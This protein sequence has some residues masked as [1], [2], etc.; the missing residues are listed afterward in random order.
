MRILLIHQNYPGQYREIVPRLAADGSHDIHFL[1]Q[2]KTF[3]DPHGHS[4]HRYEPTELPADSHPFTA[5]YQ[6][7]IANGLGA[8]KAAAN[9][10]KKGF[11]PDVIVGHAGWGELIFIKEV[12]PDTP[13]IGYFEYFFIPKCGMIGFDPEFREAPDIS[14]R[15]RAR[16]APNYLSLEAVDTGYTATEWQKQ[17]YPALFHHKIDVFHEGVRTDLL[18][19]DH[20]SPITVTLDNI[21]FS[22]D[23]ELVTYIARNLEPPRGFHV[24]M[25]ALP[26]LQKQRPNA[27]VAIIGGDDVSYG[28]RLDKGDTF[29]AR[30][31]REL[32]DQVDWSRVHFLGQIPYT[33]LIDLLKLSRCHVYLTA[34][35][36]VSW[37]MLEAMALE[38]VIVAS[39]VA[40]VRQFIEDGKTGH[41][42]DFFAP[43]ALA[44]KIADVLTDPA[45][46]HPITKAARQTI[47]KHH[48]FQTVGYPNFMRM[49]ETAHTW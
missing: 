12:W 32:G 7:C 35:F 17:T 2:R 31:T 27:R 40:P 33:K 11:K 22:R 41:L 34:P 45:A 24:M 5:W 19:P 20:T 10:K 8:A 26:E 3:P 48:D 14:A 47:V 18:K 36:V 46:H 6:R 43:D 39:D 29:R 44:A 28:A 37:S 21:T 15:L 13:L 16:N 23:D 9:L 30:L 42:V 4:V 38:K 1:T 49:L 25:R